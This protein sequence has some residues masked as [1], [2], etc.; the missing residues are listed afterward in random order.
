MLDEVSKLLATE[1]FD[2]AAVLARKVIQ[3]KL[4]RQEGRDRAIGVQNVADGPRPRDC[5]QVFVLVG[6][7]EQHVAAVLVL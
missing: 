6:N 2:E 3:G 7:L 4:L 5:V 1:R